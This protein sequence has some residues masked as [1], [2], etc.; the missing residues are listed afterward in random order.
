[1]ILCRV[2]IVWDFSILLS[3]YVVFHIFTSLFSF[4]YMRGSFDCFGIFSLRFLLPFMGVVFTPST[5][6]MLHN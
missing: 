3:F 4:C 6:S 5:C 2:D 1:M